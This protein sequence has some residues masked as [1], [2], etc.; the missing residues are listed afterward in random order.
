MNSALVTMDDM[1]KMAAA[2]VKS[3]MFGFK[4]IEEAMSIMLI[5]QAEGR[6]AALAAR[7]YHV[8]Q[9]RPALKA[10]AMLAR[11]QQEGGVVEWAEYTDQK[12][13][14]KFSHPKSCP[15]PVTITWTLDM[16]KR[17]GL[18]TRENWRN[19][20]RAM[21]RSRVISE[22][23]RTTYP[24]IA[25]GIYTVDEMQD[26]AKEKDITPTAG[27]GDSLTEERRVEISDL[28]DRV[29]EWMNSGSLTDAHAEMDNAA[30]DA[31]EQ[32][33]LWTHFDSRARRQLKEEG[34]RQRIRAKA[35]EAPTEDRITEA[36]KRRLEARIVETH[37]DREAAK[38]YC[39]HK[40]GKEHFQDLT[41]EEYK[42]VDAMMD[43]I[44]HVP[45]V[46]TAGVVQKADM[47]DRAG[48]NSSA[49]SNTQGNTKAHP[50]TT[51]EN[52]VPTVSAPNSNRE[53]LTTALEM[54][55]SVIRAKFKGVMAKNGWV[56]TADIPAD[57]LPSA[58]KFISSEVDKANAREAARIEAADREAA[59]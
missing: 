45:A 31:D 17:I 34:D 11:F 43:S 52:P 14:G 59:Q 39:F 21:L 20:P 37:A 41:K 50:A 23:V 38:E 5:A 8:I 27:A 54:A 42:D 24:G 2:M 32:I 26:L 29:R 33:F 51:G 28:A 6:P 7:D 10:D 25:V 4:T 49:P 9:G 16:A 58:L 56:E 55:S 15:V 46:T 53:S 40:F 19:Y 47:A 3:K 18:A 13:S 48:M 44:E 1:Q 36:Q 35:L 57:E 12:V 22:G 30:L